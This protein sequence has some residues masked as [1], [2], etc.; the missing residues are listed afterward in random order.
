MRAQPSGSQRQAHF[1]VIEFDARTLTDKGNRTVRIGEA[2]VVK[3][4]FPSASRAQAGAW[5]TAIAND[6]NGK[7]RTIELDRL[8]AAMATLEAERPATRAPLRNDPPHVILSSVPALLVVIDGAPVYLP[9]ARTSL[10]RVINTR[11]LLVRDGAGRYSLKVFDGWMT[12]AALEGPWSVQASASPDLAR[13]FKALSDAHVIDPLTGQT[14]TDQPAPKLA[15]SAPAIFVATHP[16]E[17]IVTEGAPE[18]TP[19][20]GTH[21]LYV[22]NTTGNVFKDSADD[23]TYVLVSGRWFRAR[24]D[25]GPWEY[26]AS[27]ALPADFAQIP[28][29]SVKENVKA[30]VAGTPQAREAAIAATIP[31][32]A[33]VKLTGTTLPPP[34]LDG[35]PVLKPIAGTSLSYVANTTVPIIRVS[36]RSWYAVANGVWFV[37][38][39]MNGPWAVA[40]SVPTAIYAIPPSAPLY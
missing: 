26:V 25:S 22:S 1:G 36:D 5:S 13:A 33:A 12:A 10:Q 30:S 14:A 40:T 2:R 24:N 35:S 8:E 38:T 23:R 27:N 3:S 4:E 7:S 15:H 9:V 6:F 37:S 11:P 18:Y 39:S 32:I 34:K 20:A 19:I 31:Q 28:D 17:L 16:A 29:D 21:L